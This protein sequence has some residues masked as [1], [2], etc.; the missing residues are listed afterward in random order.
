MTEDFSHFLVSQGRK[1][2]FFQ[3][4]KNSLNILVS[5]GSKVAQHKGRFSFD[6]T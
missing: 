5:I 1:K 2:Y 3:Q 6:Q 4:N